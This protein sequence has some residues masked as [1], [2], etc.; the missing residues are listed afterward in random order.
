VALTSGFFF[1]PEVVATWCVF[2]ESIS[3]QAAQRTESVQ[4]LLKVVPA[5]LAIDPVFPRWYSQ[6]L[7]RRFRF[8][9]CR[10]ALLA[11]PVNRPLL[12]TVG[13]RSW[14]D[15]LVLG[16]L[17]RSAVGRHA[18]IAALGWLW[19]R[20]RPYAL[21]SLVRTAAARHAERL[22]GSTRPWKR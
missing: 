7:Q 4:R 16:A 17:S 11:D 20:L 9:V 5:R 13:V 19:L 2:L 8:A 1:V 12:T 14:I 3:R 10:L 18:R 15:H 6:L 21:L 22:V